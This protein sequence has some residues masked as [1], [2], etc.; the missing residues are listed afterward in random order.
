MDNG[1]HGSG[2]AYS[3]SVCELLGGKNAPEIN[4]GV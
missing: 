3:T 4:R 1:A 2:F